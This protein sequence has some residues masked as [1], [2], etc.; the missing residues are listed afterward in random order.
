MHDQ[1]LIDSTPL[2]VLLA[3]DEPI[4]C[5]FV[6]R[7]LRRAGYIVDVVNDGEKALDEIAKG[8]YQMLVTDWDMP[9]LDGPTLCQRVRK[10]S[11]PSYLYILILTGHTTTQ[12]VVAGLDA[13]A[14]DYISKPPNNAELLARLRAGRRVVRLEQSLRESNARVQLLSITDE[15]LGV[16]NRRYLNEKLSDEIHR[17]QR[18]KRPLSIVIADLDHFKDV[19]DRYGHQAGDEVLKCFARL[20]QSRLR[21]ACDWIAR[22]G[23]EEFVFVLPEATGEGGVVTAEKIRHACSSAPLLTT[24][25]EINVTASFGV[26]E[27][28]LDERGAPAAQLDFLLRRADA[29]LYRSKNG[30]RNRVTRAES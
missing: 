18:Y 19:N 27:L 17:A 30:G 1:F 24:T 28:Q 21:Q 16:F 11:L 23:G 3:E 2:H 6:S 4:Q 12:S 25:A 9:R 15:L 20:A 5:L 22:F 29:A 7:L 10:L 8:T 14:D 13:G 26:A